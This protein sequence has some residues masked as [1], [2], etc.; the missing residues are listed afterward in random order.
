MG[1]V[2]IA[3]LIAKQR[4]WR[5][6]PRYLSYPPPMRLAAAVA[7][8]VLGVQ[9]LGQG[10]LDVGRERAGRVVVTVGEELAAL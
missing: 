8:L 5:N 4:E 2:G 7:V 9:A 10:L 1:T 3:P 6:C